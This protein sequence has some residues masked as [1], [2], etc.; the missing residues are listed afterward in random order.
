VAPTAETIAVL[1]YLME[2]PDIHR[3]TH[4]NQKMLVFHR[5]TN[6]EE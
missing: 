2:L 1:A 6:I 5:G 3:Q 4:Q